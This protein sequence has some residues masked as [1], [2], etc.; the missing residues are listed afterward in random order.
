M[1]VT[2]AIARKELFQVKL[3][4]T[5]KSGPAQSSS[6][7]SQDKKLTKL[8]KIPAASLFIIIIAKQFQ[9]VVYS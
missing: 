4:N 5:G 8:Q 1:R 7:G 2:I 3:L 6:H 9:R